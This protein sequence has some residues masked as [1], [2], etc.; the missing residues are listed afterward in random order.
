VN[1]DVPQVFRHADLVFSGTLRKAEYGEKLTFEAD[2]IWKGVVKRQVVVY[3][4]PLHR[5]AGRYVYVV[6]E[7]Y[8]LFASLLTP[9]GRT[10]SNVPSNEDQ[11]FGIPPSCGAPPRPLT[12]VPELDKIARGRKP[13]GRMPR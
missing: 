11:A 6:G 9:D 1:V 13:R 10:M 5:Y 3:D 7:R 8:L 4:E 2:R 12:L